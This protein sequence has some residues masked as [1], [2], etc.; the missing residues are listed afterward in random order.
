MSNKTTKIVAEGDFWRTKKVLEKVPFSRST[1]YRLIEAGQ[2]PSQIKLSSR[3]S[4]WS[5][6]DVLAWID[7]R[8]DQVE[9]V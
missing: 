2:F 4:V 7:G 8:R 5:S 9:G 1:L 3:I 6:T